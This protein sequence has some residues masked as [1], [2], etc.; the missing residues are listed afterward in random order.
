MQSTRDVA[1]QY[2][3]LLCAQK[4]ADAFDML[5]DQATYRIIGTTAIS[6]PMT[7]RET[8]KAILVPALTSF[9]TPPRLTCHEIIV[10]GN[11]AVGL[12]SGEG[13]GPTGIAYSQAHY[14]MVLSIKNGQIES[15]VEYMDTV[16]VEVALLGNKL[17]PD[18]D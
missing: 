7:G 6:T 12:S 14:A 8:I 2:M 9:R 13:V 17:V 5:A 4:F 3:N 11:R 1:Q 16:A 15:V 18:R 10:E